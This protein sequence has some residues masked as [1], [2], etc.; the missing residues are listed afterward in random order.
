MSSSPPLRELHR[1]RQDREALQLDQR[2]NVAS[3]GDRILETRPVATRTEPDTPELSGGTSGDES[4]GRAAVGR[5]ATNRATSADAD[6]VAETESVDQGSAEPVALPRPELLV[7][8][9]AERELLRR[10]G[11]LIPT[12]RAAKRLVNIYRMLRV[13]VPERELDEFRPGGGSHYEAVVLLLGILV[14]RPALAND[15]FTS[16]MTSKDS[17]NIWQV[18]SKFP[19]VHGPLADVRQ[20]VTV[21][22]AGPYRRWAP[23]VSRFSFRLATV[24]PMNEPGS[25]ERALPTRAKSPRR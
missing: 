25:R 1:M 12:P 21:T 14:G 5:I 17:A 2:A 10:L 6:E 9:I 13:S 15:V 19:D 16:V 11:G 20:H 23:R 18:L 22:Q 8:S 4:G 3:N 7:I 24:I